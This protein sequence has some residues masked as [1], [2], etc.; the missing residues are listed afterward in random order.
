[1]NHTSIIILNV[2]DRRTIMLLPAYREETV[3]EGHDLYIDRLDS[4]KW[5]FLDLEFQLRH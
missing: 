4:G 3:A 5:P 2:C 1:M